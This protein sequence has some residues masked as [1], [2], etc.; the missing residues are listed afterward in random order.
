MTEDM[1]QGSDA[2]YGLQKMITFEF[3]PIGRGRIRVKAICHEPAVESAFLWLLEQIGEIS[4]ESGLKVEANQSQRVSRLP[5][6]DSDPLAAPSMPKMVDQQRRRYGP[7]RL[8][9]KED[10]RKYAQEWLKLKERGGMSQSAYADEI[11]VASR[12]LRLYVQQF[13]CGELE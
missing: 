10:R 5:A 3:L 4:P 9:S 12:T 8:H 13:L 1:A 11:G 6:D 7:P 2:P